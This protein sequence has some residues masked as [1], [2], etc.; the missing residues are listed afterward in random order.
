M[1]NTSTLNEKITIQ[2]Y[3]LEELDMR[4]GRV[5]TI[6]RGTNSLICRRNMQCI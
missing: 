6:E 4:S 5:D 1:K 2:K 3:I